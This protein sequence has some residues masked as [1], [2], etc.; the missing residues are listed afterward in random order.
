MS[1]TVVPQV[2][3]RPIT[4]STSATMIV[5]AVGAKVVRDQ[6]HNGLQSGPFIR[7]LHETTT[8]WPSCD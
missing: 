4:I 7:S 3:S 2:P 6:R 1:G 8:S 5:R